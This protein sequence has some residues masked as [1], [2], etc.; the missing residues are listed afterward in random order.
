MKVQRGIALGSVDSIYSALVYVLIELSIFLLFTAVLSILIRTSRHQIWLGIALLTLYL[1]TLCTITVE[2]LTHELFR[3]TG[4]ILNWPMLVFGI[5]RS[6]MVFKALEQ[7]LSTATTYY[8]IAALAYLIALPFLLMRIIR[9]NKG[10]SHRYPGIGISAVSLIVYGGLMLFSSAF[11]PPREEFRGA[12][13]HLVL[14]YFEDKSPWQTQSKD[15]TDS[16]LTGLAIPEGVSIGN[17]LNVAIVILEST[18]ADSVA[19]YV[20]T[21]VTPYLFE[22]AQTSLIAEHAYSTTPHT[23][24]AIY[25]ILCGQFPRSGKGIIETLKNGIRQAC[26][27]HLLEKQGYASAFFQSATEDFEHRAQ[28]IENMGFSNF[29]PLEKF[30]TTDFEKSNYFGYEDNIM[31]PTSKE[32]LTSQ[33]QPFLASYL[34]VTPHF[35]YDA[36]SRYGW[37]NYVNDK[38]YNAYLNTL[39]YQDNFLKNLIQQYKD[40][41]L[42][43]ST[44][45]VILGDHGEA[46]REH[47]LWGHGNILYEEG[48]KV[49]FILHYA[50]ELK[51]KVTSRVNLQDV[52]PSILSQLQFDGPNNLFPGQDLHRPFEERDIILECISPNQCSSLIDAETGLKL[53]HNY[54]RK[55][56][57]LFDLLSDPR[58]TN[59]LIEEPQYQAIKLNLLTRLQSR[60]EAIRFPDIPQAYS[61]WAYDSRPVTWM[62]DLPNKVVFFQNK[63]TMNHIEGGAKIL[64]VSA[65]KDHVFAGDSFNLSYIHSGSD[66]TIC[67]ESLFEGIK[68]HKRRTRI[69]E[70]DA[71]ADSVYFQVTEN[72]QVLPD[73]STITVDIS[74]KPDCSSGA[75]VLSRNELVIELPEKDV[76]VVFSS[77]YK[78]LFQSQPLPADSKALQSTRYLSELLDPQLPADAFSTHSLPR[79]RSEEFVGGIRNRISELGSKYGDYQSS[80]LD[81]IWKSKDGG[82]TMIYR[83]QLLFSENQSMDFRVIVRNSQIV[84]LYYYHP[85]RKN[86]PL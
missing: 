60:I 30:D 26:L 37:K 24:R 9:L 20:D 57:V 28:L 23:S 18:R 15:N 3:Q 43:E 21:E 40:L 70:P 84:A 50:G 48:V 58:E 52:V 13:S 27:P 8:F 7:Q 14:S 4:L 76:D 75:T 82:S 77:K 10:A 81:S 45:F 79:L 49:P 73:A 1:L 67:I 65:S 54:Q 64:K 34:T 59:N 29:F 69:V 56:D 35:H 41:D 74:T 17:R 11:G 66:K 71:D 80:K 5:E 38:K 36:I 33:D 53:I 62:S 19:P 78:K 55:P 16:E 12:F 47:R 6:E 39:H 32:W 25:S 68:R 61:S 2:L 85:W 86:K 63:V 22:L 31:L 72:L 44:L 42:Y 46:F 51:G 83:Y